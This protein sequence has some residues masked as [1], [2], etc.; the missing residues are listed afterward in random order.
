MGYEINLKQHI[1]D[2][3]FTIWG[4]SNYFTLQLKNTLTLKEVLSHLY[5]LLPILDGE[6][7]YWLSKHEVD[8]LMEKGEGWLA[9]HPEM[10]LITKRYLRNLKELTKIAFLQLAEN[11]EDESLNEE[12]EQ[13]LQTEEQQNIRQAR[14]SLHQLRLTSVVEKL[15]EL[16]VSSIADWD[17]AKVNC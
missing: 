4:N 7:H 6:K 11:Q 10:K 8:K 13:E 2:E 16:G 5:L 17:V 15:K 1:L 3:K 14:F 9:N 12:L